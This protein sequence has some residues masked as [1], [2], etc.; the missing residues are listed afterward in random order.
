LTPPRCIS[1]RVLTPIKNRRPSGR[2]QIRE[3][4]IC[5]A[6]VQIDNIREPTSE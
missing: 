4:E 6:G 5:L 3:T 1:L 2:A